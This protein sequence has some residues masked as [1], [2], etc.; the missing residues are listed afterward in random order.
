MWSRLPRLVSCFCLFCGLGLP[1]TG[2]YLRLFY[3]DIE[4]GSATI[5]VAPNGTA[6]LV[7]AGPEKNPDD[8]LEH[9]VASLMERGLITKLAYIVATHYDEDHI[10][11]MDKLLG[12]LP[13]APDTQI[14]DR[15]E[16]GKV[17]KTFAYRDYK[18]AAAAFQRRTIAPGEI[19]DLGDGVT[20]TCVAVNGMLI[21]GN[22]VDL[23]EASQFE[24]AASV[25]LVVRF[26]AFDAFIGGDL[27]GNESFSL[28]PVEQRVAPA[29][30]DVDIYTVNHHGSRTSST[31][32]FL[33]QLK[34]EVAICQNAAN[35]RHGHPNERIVRRIKTTANSF[36]EPPLFFQTNLSKLTDPRADYRLADGI[37]DP[38]DGLAPRGRGGSIQVISDGAWYRVSAPLIEPVVRPCDGTTV[39]DGD[40]TGRERFPP[41]ILDVFRDLYVPPSNRRTRILARVRF[42]REALDRRAHV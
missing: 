24:N 17:P 15:G 21:D 31:E 6:M 7:D 14:L 22:R 25:A 29:I 30:G 1:L 33:A 3:P 9:Y 19:L 13:L 38:D 18:T 32:P 5:V 2:Q 40:P 23:S 42:Y 35:N 41:A 39:G 16:F 11:R 34:P 28:P 26:G 4:Q 20:V 12:F 36:G 37:A 27:L 8:V 10:G